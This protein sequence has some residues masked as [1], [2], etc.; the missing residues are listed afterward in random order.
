MDIEKSI[1]YAARGEA[2]LFLGAGFSLGVK[3]V[4]GDKLPTGSKLAADLASAVGLPNDT[5]LTLAAECFREANGTDALIDLIK[6]MFTAA[7]PVSEVYSAIAGLSWRR[8]YTTNYDNLFEKS[9]EAA[10][11]TCFSVTLSDRVRD[12]P[13]GSTCCVHLNGFVDRLDRNTVDTELKLTDSSYLSRTLLESEWSLLL[14]QD[15]RLVKAVVFLGYSL[16]DYEIRKLLI[17][18]PAI[19]EKSVFILGTAPNEALVTQ[20]RRYGQ[21]FSIS[22]VDYGGQV[23]IAVAKLSSEHAPALND[24]FVALREFRT[25]PPAEKPSDDALWRLL[26][27]GVVEPKHLHYSVTADDGIVLPRSKIKTAKKH[28]GEGARFFAVISELGNG[29]SIFLQVLQHELL[30]LGYR[31]FWID[32]SGEVA[33]KELINLCGSPGKKAFFL[34]GYPERLSLVE[35]FSLNAT[36]ES[37]LFVT[38]RTSVHDLFVEPLADKTN[39]VSPIEL[40]LDVMDDAEAEWFS[41]LLTNF[42]MWGDRAGAT[43]RTKLKIIRKNCD[44]QV[45]AVLLRIFES[46]NI[47]QKI[48]ELFAPLEGHQEILI[49]LM[50]M[51]VIGRPTRADLLADIVG[52]EAISSSLLRTDPRIRQLVG[53]D[54]HTVN[55]RSP[56]VAEFYLN[57]IASRSSILSVL[58]KLAQRADKGRHAGGGFRLL[59]ES[60]QRFS[61]IQRIFPKDGK[62]EAVITYYENIK[63]LE[64]SVK[65]YHFWLQYAIACLTLGERT[66]SQKYFDQAFAIARDRGRDAYMVDNHYSRYLLETA[67]E[68]PNPDEAIECF[69]TARDIINRQIRDERLHYPYRVALQYVRFVNRFGTRLQEAWV[70]EIEQAAKAIADRIPEL[71]EE[72]QRN[73]YVSQCKRDM[74]YVLYKCT[75]IRS[76]LANQKTEAKIPKVGKNKR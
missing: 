19:G 4:T 71:V 45:H 65:N 34:E 10:K 30:A 12:I 23:P 14:R 59:F 50:V 54:S 33:E 11:K 32:E 28:L 5:P 17:D 3:S 60:L 25:P 31:V 47:Q 51:A 63:V 8:I 6:G 40:R 44:G 57:H 41:R 2:I 9:V 18:I 61:V 46:P 36:E 62:L 67:V 26:L 7:T 72:R 69:R 38:A 35:A 49:C 52:A 24:V 58:I 1:Q 64:G 76:N 48:K 13:K 43:E 56:I 66:R 39:G 27:Q 53:F 74:E 22:T 21:P 15:L 55:V 75:N 73:R 70:D 37:C 29:K 20:I 68:F 42:G 16:Y